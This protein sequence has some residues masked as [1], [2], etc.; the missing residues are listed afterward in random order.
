MRR[1]GHG[2]KESRKEVGF[3]SLPSI[4]IFVSLSLSLKKKRRKTLPLLTF[5]SLDR[6]LDKPFPLFQINVLHV[7]GRA[8]KDPC[9]A[10]DDHPHR[11]LP[12]QIEHHRFVR[13]VAPEPGEY[14]LVKRNFQE[15]GRDQRLHGPGHARGRVAAQRERQ[16]GTHGEAGV[17][18]VAKDVLAPGLRVRHARHDAAAEAAAPT[19]PD[20]R[21]DDGGPASPAG[22]SGGQNEKGHD[23]RGGG[24]AEEEGGEEGPAEDEG[25]DLGEAV[26][27]I[28][29][30]W[31]LLGG[32]RERKDSKGVRKRERE[33]ERRRK[34]REGRK[35]ER[36]LKRE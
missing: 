26:V 24:G 25:Q 2:R 22:Q 30:S 13:R 31:R 34:K 14:V 32:E 27:V 15:D 29:L 19:V 8:Q 5:P 10:L 17:R 18:E 4:I 23:A 28:V 33:Q 36:A 12:Q 7:P 1:R 35:T 3:F 20:A 21:V 16:E 11:V 6:R 9:D